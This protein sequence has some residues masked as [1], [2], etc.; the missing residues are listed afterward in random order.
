[1]NRTKFK[2]TRDR[3]MILAVNLAVKLT[4]TGI[5]NEN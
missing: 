1:M 4:K 5:L 3:N 2:L